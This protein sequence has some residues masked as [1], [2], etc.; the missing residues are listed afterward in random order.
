MMLSVLLSVDQANLRQNEPTAPADRAVHQW[1][2]DWMPNFDVRFV[3]LISVRSKV[4]LLPGPL[5]L[6][7]VVVAPL[8]L[9]M[10]VD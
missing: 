8:T 9:F 3:W 4:Q 7:A 1:F 10:I 6:I 5:F 2:V